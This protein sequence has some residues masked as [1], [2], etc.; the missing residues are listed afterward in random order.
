ML[1]ST[2]PVLR[3]KSEVQKCN[4]AEVKENGRSSIGVFRLQRG[5]FQRGTYPTCGTQ[6]SWKNQKDIQFLHENPALYYMR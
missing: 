6:V 1:A 4:S 2:H 5:D 3:S